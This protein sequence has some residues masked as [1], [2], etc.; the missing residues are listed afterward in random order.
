MS[1]LSQNQRHPIIIMQYVCLYLYVEIVSSA[2]TTLILAQDPS[3]LPH[4]AKME[5]QKTSMMMSYHETRSFVRSRK[6]STLIEYVIH[7]QISGIVNSPSLI[8]NRIY[9]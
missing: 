4:A 8:P 7:A 9:L 6:L 5:D 1:G 2:R 3:P